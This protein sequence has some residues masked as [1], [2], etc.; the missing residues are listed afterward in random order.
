M[1]LSKTNGGTFGIVSFIEEYQEFAKLPYRDINCVGVVALKFDDVTESSSNLNKAS[2]N[3][4]DMIASFLRELK[5]KQVET[6][7]VNCYAGI[8]RSSAVG[9]AYSL[10]TLGHDR[11]I[12]SHHKYRPNMYIYRELV[13]R[14]IGEIV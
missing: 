5:D 2:A 12:F 6:L 13:N 4:L 1:L 10:Y 9:A 3:Q 14:L 11:E 7:L 8:S